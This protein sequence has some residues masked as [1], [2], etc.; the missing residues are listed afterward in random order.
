MFPSLIPNE[1]R[2]AAS[3]SFQVPPPSK[4]RAP[5]GR[6]RDATVKIIPYERQKG[7][8]AAQ[9]N[10]LRFEA[11]VQEELFSH[12][13]GRYVVSPIIHFLDDRGPRIVIPD[14]LFKAQRRVDGVKSIVIVEIKSQHMPEAWWQLRKLYQPVIE[15]CSAPYPVHVLEIV[16]SFDPSMPFPEPVRLIDD[17][18]AYLIAPFKEFGVFKWT[19]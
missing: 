11:T 13:S 1:A 7:R 3:A 9:E 17:L 14:G 6:I 16:K 2:S 4:F 12:L 5:S 15:T 10:G 18:D 8:T 19:R